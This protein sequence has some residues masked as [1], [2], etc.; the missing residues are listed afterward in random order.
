MKDKIEK[1]A[2]NKYIYIIVKFTNVSEKNILFNSGLF[3]GETLQLTNLLHHTIEPVSN[4][5]KI[6]P[7][8]I[9]KFGMKGTEITYK[10]IYNNLS[11]SGIYYYQNILIVRRKL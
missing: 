1:K 10:Q 8:L 11:A 4:M 5:A 6:I 7:M 9:A 3:E 2:R